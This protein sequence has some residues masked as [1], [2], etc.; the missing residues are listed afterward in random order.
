MQAG[1]FRIYEELFNQFGHLTI[2]IPVTKQILF[3]PVMV[4]IY[5]E[6]H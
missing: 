2:T 6:K 5:H 1:S 4:L 3:L